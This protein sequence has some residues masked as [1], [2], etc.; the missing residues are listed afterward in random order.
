MASAQQE[1]REQMAAPVAPPSPIPTG[2]LT[3]PMLLA[4]GMDVTRYLLKYLTPS[5]RSARSWIH[6]YTSQQLCLWLDCDNGITDVSCLGSVHTLTLRA[7]SRITDVNALGS[8]RTLTLENCDGV[9]DV[10]AL[11][12]VHS[13]E[14]HGCNG[15]TDVSALGSVH[16]LTLY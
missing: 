7:C 6:W 11:G 9:A 14:L 3:L 13:L 12:S 5:L 4:W 10:S 15:I 2:A 16:N 8:V 1:K